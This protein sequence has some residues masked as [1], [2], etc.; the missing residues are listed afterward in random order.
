MVQ[1]TQARHKVEGCIGERSR[2]QV[3]TDSHHI[4]KRGEVPGRDLDCRRG[5]AGYEHAHVERQ[6]TGETA[7][8]TARIETG[9]AG[10][11]VQA[12]IRQVPAREY[13]VLGA[14]VVEGR[15]LVAE[16]LGGLSAHCVGPSGAERPE[17]AQVSPS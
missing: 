10:E 11:L 7:F 13:L 12:K 16:T 14:D 2:P 17:S 8:A 6:V 15:P 1:R 4:G 5:V 9:L 3:A